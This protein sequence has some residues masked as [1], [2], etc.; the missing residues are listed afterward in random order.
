M[1]LLVVGWVGGWIS[2]VECMEGGI[3]LVLFLCCVAW[4]SVDEWV[5]LCLCVD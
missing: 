1:P 4:C 2:E 5:C 3:V